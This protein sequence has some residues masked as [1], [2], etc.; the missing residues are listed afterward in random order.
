MSEVTLVRAPRTVWNVECRDK[1]GN[2]KWEEDINN[3]VTDEGV[4][5][6]L[7]KYFKG[8]AYTAAWYV[9]LIADGAGALA[10]TDTAASHAGW[11]EF[12]DYTSVTRPVLTL[13]AVAAKSASNSASRA[14]FTLNLAGTIRGCFLAT[15]AAK[16]LTSGLIY[17]EALF[18]TGNKVLA[19]GDTVAISCSVSGA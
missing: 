4:N 13:G 7:N 14:A 10:T 6:L 11:T 5:D 3:L 16:G 1:D 17:S 12:V 18:T 19:N 2:L 15:S 9:G 8:S